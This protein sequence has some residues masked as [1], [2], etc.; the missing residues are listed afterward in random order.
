MLQKSFILLHFDV[1]PYAFSKSKRV[2][3]LIIG[4]DQDKNAVFDLGN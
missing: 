2:D 1:I 3:W 4:R